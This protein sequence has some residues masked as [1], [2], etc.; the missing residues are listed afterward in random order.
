MLISITSESRTILCSQKYLRVLAI[1]EIAIATLLAIA[2]SFA[3]WVV[4]L[5]ILVFFIVAVWF[6][7]KSMSMYRFT[8]SSTEIRTR[9]VFTNHIDVTVPTHQVQTVSVHQGI[10]EAF[11]DAGT[12]E[13][14]TASSKS[15][16]SHFTWPHIHDAREIAKELRLAVASKR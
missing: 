11:L 10:L 12:I 3:H 8:F 9:K 4:G 13:I 15:D 5:L 7:H 6:Q 14:S 1:F 2:F 16:H